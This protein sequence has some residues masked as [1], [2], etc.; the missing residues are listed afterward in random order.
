MPKELQIPNRETEL[1][2]AEL[3]KTL[4]LS[5]DVVEF[6]CYEGD[7]SILL[8]DAL[9]NQPD[10][11]L[12]LYDSFEGLP[13][14]T[15]EERGGTG[16][17]LGRRGKRGRQRLAGRAAER[18]QAGASDERRDEAGQLSAGTGGERPYRR[19]EPGQGFLLSRAGRQHAGLPHPPGRHRADS[20]GEQPGGR[21]DHAADLQ[22][23]PLPAQG[24]SAG[25]PQRPPAVLRPAV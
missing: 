17:L 3:D 13:E 22:R 19:R 1:L 20:A 14:K 23:A 10:K 11:W 18:A 5:G 6:G 9:R 12:Y 21:R 4:D 7:T 8:A 15:A 24:K 16:R 2:L 25:R